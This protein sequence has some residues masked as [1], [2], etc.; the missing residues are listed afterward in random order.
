MNWIDKLE[1]KFG[2]YALR[3]IMLYLIIFYVAG[4]MIETV[5]PYFYYN[6]LSLDVSRILHG[7]VWRLV[8]FLMWPPSSNI[9]WL[10]FLSFIYYSLGRSLEQMWGT[11]RFNLYLLIGVL[12][13]ILAAFIIY[14]VWGQVWI[15]TADNLYMTMILAFAITV[16]DMQFYLYFAIPIK[17]KWIGIVDVVLLALEFYQASLPGKVAVA[18]SVLNVIVFFLTMHPPVQAAKQAKR[19]HDYEEKIRVSRPVHGGTIH[20]CAVCGRTEKD[21]PNLEFRYCSK[22]AGYMEYCSDHLYTHVHVTGER[23]DN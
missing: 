15:L 23:T 22:C 20:R 9:L 3:N 4:F 13:Y 8:T 18:M 21:D 7:Q 11:F 17:A 2:R 16:P 19:R 14:F 6:H 12:G 10:A 1:R 5:N